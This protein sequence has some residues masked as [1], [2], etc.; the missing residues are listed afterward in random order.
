MPRCPSGSGS[1]NGGNEE[2][3][4][5]PAK[6]AEAFGFPVALQLIGGPAPGR[7]YRRRGNR[8]W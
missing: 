5:A 2:T 1:L 3:P 8:T 7:P 4:K 6:A